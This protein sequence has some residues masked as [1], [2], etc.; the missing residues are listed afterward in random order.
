MLRHP[1]SQRS[2]ELYLAACV[3]LLTLA[4]PVAAGTFAVYGP[5]T[6]GRSTA[7]PATVTT[8]FIAPTL[9]TTYAIEITDNTIASAVVTLNGTQVIGPNDF[10][11]NVAQVTR[12]V[13][14]QTENTLTVELRSSPDNGFTLR[15]VGLD[16]DLPTIVG[17]VGPPPT[18]GGWNRDAA[19]VYFRC[20]DALSG[21]ATCTPAFTPVSVEGSTTV[22]GTAVD[23]AGN[24]ASA[25]V[26][27]KIDK[28]APTVAITAPVAGAV[29]HSPT[30]TISGSVADALSGVAS[31]HCGDTAV[32]VLAGAFVCTAS[33]S[34]GA[35]TISVRADDAAGNSHTQQ[36]DVR[37]SSAPTVRITEPGNFSFMNI[38]PIT[39]RG[40]VDDPAATVKVNGV[41]APVSGGLFSVVVPIVEGNNTLTAVATTATGYAGTGSVQVTLDTTPPRVTIQSPS[42]GFVTT[43]ATVN[44]TGIVNDV[45]VGTV[46]DQEAQVTVNAIAASVANRSFFASNVPLT[47]GD[48]IVQATGRDRVG[49]SFTTRVNVRRDAPVGARISTVSG[50]DQIALVSTQLPAPLV[51]RLTDAAGAPAVNQAVVFKV[52]QN[53]G[54]LSDGSQPARAAIVVRTLPDGTATARWLIGSRSGAGDN[55]VEAT[56]TGFSGAA[57]FTAT[58][59]PAA[60][61]AIFLDSGAGQCGPIGQPLAFPFVVVVTDGGHNRRVGVPVT[62]LVRS[63][64]GNLNGQST[65]TTNTDSDGRALALL[66]LGN[67]PGSDNN[68]VEAGI[69][70]APSVVFSASSKMPGTAADTKIS[71]VVFDNANTPIAGVTVRLYQAYQANNSNIPVPIGQ[72]VITDGQGQFVITQAPVG[73]FK[74]VADGTTVPGQSLSYPSVEYDITTVAGQNN[75]INSPIYLPA[76]DTVNRLCVGPTLGGTLTLPSSPGF[77]LTVAPGSATFPGGSRTGCI[78]VTPVHGDKVPMV[79]G[80]GQQPRFVVTIQPVGTHFNPPAQIS[81]PN[82][83]GLQPRQVT[84]MYSY[85]HD[86]SAF[87][88]IGT[89]TVTSDGSTIVSDPGVGVMKAGW[90]CGGDPNAS[91]AAAK[92][93]DCKK[94][95]GTDCVADASKNG[96]LDTSNC[97]FNGEK[98]PKQVPDIN[99]L[100]NKC[101]GREANDKPH[102]VD[103]CSSPLGDDPTLGAL[104]HGSTSFGQNEGTLPPGQ[105]SLNLPCNHHDLCYQR[106]KS[107]KAGCDSTFQSE[108][109]SVC[110]RAYPETTCPLTGFGIFACQT[111]YDEKS[112]CLI[113]TGVYYEAVS[114]LGQGAWNDDQVKWCKC[115]P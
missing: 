15:V 17:L 115:C 12:T 107:E 76:L 73:S 35:N 106:C 68:R 84:E 85:D 46:N 26:T 11:A 88:A 39:V 79:P 53:N 44:V 80:F 38:S 28:S 42:D 108:M 83:D 109:A 13:T 3:F 103:G 9:P 81:I 8:T 66:T 6:Y 18:S 30:L 41:S 20:D 113:Y 70:G 4:T 98:V 60:P 51:V 90:H 24:R 99:T 104:G 16:N 101:P 72:P 114:R 94:C 25:S 32:T 64:E 47:I 92:C 54:V 105:G 102:F 59:T 52:M 111:W 43:N 22:T 89:G 55:R 45:V 23:N 48:N 49:N 75:T 1:Y 77:S 58:G 82:V 91:G 5:Q 33:L 10:N 21:I 65:V 62:F 67:E 19:T 29:V 95:S 34:E 63:G 87:I 57:L 14:L 69:A 112:R 2:V 7:A 100:L 40:T 74:L 36:V 78:T 110:N 56:A 93:G 31:V 97:C 37:L 71:G 86:L 50:N 27:V 96:T 61:T